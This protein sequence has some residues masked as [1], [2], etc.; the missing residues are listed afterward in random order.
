MPSHRDPTVPRWLELGLYAAVALIGVAPALLRGQ[1]VVG[2]GVDLYGTLWFYWWI[3]D[4][5]VHLHDPGFTDLFFH[6]LGKDIFAHTGNNFVD[7]ALSAPFQW[8]FRF[9]RYQ[10]V[11]VAFLLLGNA[12]TFRPLAARFAG[13]PDGDATP[14]WR[15]A[16]GGGRSSLAAF[17]ATGLWMSCSFTLFEITAGRPTQAFLWFL[18]LAMDRLLA[19]EE[20]EP[21]QRDAL[22]A[23]IFT[24]LQALVYWFMGYF[25]LL[26]WI[27]IGAGALLSSPHKRRLLGHYALA[28]GA[29]LLLV[30]P[31]VWAMLGEASGGAVPGLIGG[32]SLL[33]PPAPLANNVATQLHGYWMMERWGAPMLGHAAW[34]TVLALVAWKGPARLRWLG[35]VTLLL[36]LAVGPSLALG[37]ER[38]IAWYPYLLLYN[39]VPFLDRLW[40]PYRLV[41][42]VFLVLSAC[43]G[44]A[45]APLLRRLRAA[46]RPELARWGPLLLAGAL[47]GANLAG[48]A[49]QLCWPFVTRDMAPP[50]AF[51]WIG[52][53]GGALLHLPFGIQQPAVV[54]Q[55]V[56]AQPL[57]GG[58][59]ENAPLL[60]PEGFE[61]RTRTDLLRFLR[62]ATRDPLGA[63]P[64]QDERSLQRLREEGFRWIVLHRDLVETE[65]RYR[66]ALDH[67][68]LSLTPQQLEAL[69]NQTAQAIAGLLGTPAAIEG[70][71]VVWDLDGGQPA[72]RALRP[73][74]DAL[75][76]RSWETEG[77]PAY[78]RRLL[79]RGRLRGPQGRDHSPGH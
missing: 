65:N 57:F 33:A 20:P 34:L 14:W 41:V 45:L 79:E 70:A 58:M 4:C 10:P 7:A 3:Q 72:P 46:P 42:M 9:P 56:H 5:I 19:L 60:W 8:V 26:L 11:F 35:A 66:L 15:R 37:P 73:A 63:T 71:L 23:G 36:A 31:F 53:E 62:R 54:W 43:A 1:H 25:Q 61:E 48:Q 55:T 76:V 22:A 50:A 30:S 12:L 49:R 40:F 6:P 28:A 47:L 44:A 38:E 52:E 68:R 18:P 13:V 74:P 69:P 24:A 67:E 2:D 78:E 27:W 29:C 75:R 51:R 77:P 16:L 32:G 17:V 59:G 64:P 39:T 21:R